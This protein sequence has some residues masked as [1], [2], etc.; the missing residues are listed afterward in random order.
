LKLEI[1]DGKLRIDLGDLEKALAIR[2]GFEI[3]LEN[4]VK[5][6]TEA[7]RTGWREVRAPG[8]HLP[9]A[10]KA[11]T[12]YTPRGREFWYVT[13]KGVLVLELEHESYT[14][15]VLSIDNNEEWAQRIKEAITGRQR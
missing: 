7:H 13:E 2:G 4:I 12:Y 8:T 5:A 6:G 3:P 14:R 1:S 11:G 15:I 10:I 9:G